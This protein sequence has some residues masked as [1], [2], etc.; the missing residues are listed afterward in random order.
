ML[1]F[2]TT[3]LAPA[4][5]KECDEFFIANYI[6]AENSLVCPKCAK[7]ALFYNDQSIR[8]VEVSTRLIFQWRLTKDTSFDLPDTKYYCPKCKTYELKFKEVGLWD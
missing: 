2:E 4:V 1:N 6:D 8:G 7:K 5:C 3:C